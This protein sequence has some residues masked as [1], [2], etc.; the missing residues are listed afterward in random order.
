[1]ELEI[2]RFLCV[3]LLASITFDEGTN[4]NVF[5]LPKSSSKQTLQSNCGAN[6][7]KGYLTT[8]ATVHAHLNILLV[9]YVVLNLIPSCKLDRETFVFYL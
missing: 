6:S 5:S 3:V 1:M 9:N 4:K 8:L 7:Q 2:K